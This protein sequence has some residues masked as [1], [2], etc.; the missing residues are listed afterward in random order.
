MPGASAL[1]AV[2]FLTRVPVGRRVEATDVARGALFF[3]VVGAAIGGATA[4]IALL[5]HLALSPLLA[6]ALGV[7]A[8]TLLTGALHLDALADTADALGGATRERR[9][10]IMRDSRLGSFGAAALVLD[11]LIKLAAIAQLVTAGK[12]LVALVAAGALSRGASVG[13]AGRLPY[14][15]AS[16]T[17]GVL[18]GASSWTAM[19]VACAIA[20][21]AFR[22]D[23]A[24]VLGCVA[25]LV[26]ALALAY[27]RWLGGVTGDTLGAA[28]ELSE[29]LAL[30]VSAALA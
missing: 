14:A 24:I 18:G 27:R 15:R 4:G 19:F 21:G 30:V 5:A 16:G 6:A 13:V 2:S 23:G 1:A 20:V 3:P 7:A 22:L 11:V 10:E 28:I 8:A 29:T 9:L 12:A 25:A 17:G 26:V